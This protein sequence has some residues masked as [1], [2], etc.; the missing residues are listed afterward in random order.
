MNKLL[1]NRVTIP[2][3]PFYRQ[4]PYRNGISINSAD[5]RGLVDFELGVFCN[6]IPKAANSSVVT[7]LAYHKLGHT[8]P[9]RD[10]KKLFTFPSELSKQQVAK[11]PTLFTFAFVRNPYTRVLS[12]FLDK[13]DR[14]ARRKNREIT[15]LEFL[16]YLEEGGLYTNAH[17]AP[18]TSLLLLPFDNFHFFG[19]TEHLDNDLSYVLQKLGLPV[20]HDNVLSA[21]GNATGATK[22]LELYYDETNQEKVKTLYANDF[23]SFGYSTQLPC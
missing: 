18:Q 3:T 20:D 16:N 19:K 23:E 6:R 4:Y 17:W 13:V 9:D 14:R 8:I 11:L 22:K 12:A 21:L 2:W 7:N 5:A 15:F 10:A 1:R